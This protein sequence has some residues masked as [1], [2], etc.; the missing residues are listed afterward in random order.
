MKSA[1]EN[2]LRANHWLLQPGVRKWWNNRSC[3]ARARVALVAATQLVNFGNLGQLDFSSLGDCMTGRCTAGNIPGED[4]I[5]VTNLFALEFN[6]DQVINDGV[7]DLSIGILNSVFNDVTQKTGD[8]HC[9]S[10]AFES[11]P[12]IPDPRSCTGAPAG[13]RCHW[14]P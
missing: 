9:V 8:S 11:K 12:L 10:A 4:A 1:F 7:A 3:L 2:A 6:V 13:S 14:C 5:I